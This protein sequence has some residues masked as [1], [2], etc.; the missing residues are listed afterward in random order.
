MS[1]HTGLQTILLVA[2]RALVILTTRVSMHDF[3]MVFHIVFQA[4]LLVA[5]S[6]LVI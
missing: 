5:E 1:F 3:N 2:E 4:K 6:T